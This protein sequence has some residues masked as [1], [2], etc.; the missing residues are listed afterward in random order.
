MAGAGWTVQP[1]TVAWAALPLYTYLRFSRNLQP[2][3]AEVARFLVGTAVLFAALVSPLHWIADRSSFLFHVVQHMMLQM[4]A[5]PLLLLGIPRHAWVRLG[6]HRTAARL[7]RAGLHPVV[8]AGIYNAVL[9]FWHWPFPAGDGSQ[10]LAC[11]VLT[12]LATQSPVAAVLQDLLPLLAGLLF[13]GSVILAPPLSP[14]TLPTRVAMLLGSMV[15]NWLISFPIAMS[16]TPMYATYAGTRPP[17][18]LSLL[19]DQKLGAGILWE[20]GNMTYVVALLAQLRGL[21]WDRSAHEAP[22]HPAGFLK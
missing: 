18:G 12:D 15:L 14:A 8:A 1:H 6:E 16:E 4:G 21:L 19:A 13:W 17:F 22:P 5:P 11:G 9:F 7:I 2:S 10:R 20:H 3:R